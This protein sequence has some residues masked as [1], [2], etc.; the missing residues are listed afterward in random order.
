MPLVVEAIEN[1]GADILHIPTGCSGFCQPLDV[2]IAKPIKDHF[3]P[4][5]EE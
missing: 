2:E 3:Q 1:L 4:N 5:W